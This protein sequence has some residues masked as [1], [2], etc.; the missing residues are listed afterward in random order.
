M[1]TR[2]LN[3]KMDE[4]EILD[5]KEVAGVF[6]MSITDLVKN[7]VKEYVT[8]LKKD[9]FYRLTANVQEASEEESEEILAAI[10][11]M[12]DDDLTIT[13]TKHFSV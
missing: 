1:A 9:P 4:A 2:A 11:E 3:F 10:E 8:E 7:A 6:N 5:M 13:S 12:S